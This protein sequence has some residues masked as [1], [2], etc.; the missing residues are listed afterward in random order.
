MQN[1]YG[2]ISIS[3][4]KV[5]LLLTLEPILVLAFVITAMVRHV[6][7]VKKITSYKTTNVSSKH[8]NVQVNVLL[9]LKKII[10]V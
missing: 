4:L 6:N 7:L 2:V 8:M 9:A 10:F 5:L 3:V 1:V